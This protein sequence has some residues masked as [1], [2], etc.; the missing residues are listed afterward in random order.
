MIIDTG[1]WI[2]L[3]EAAELLGVSYQTLSAY[4]IRGQVIPKDK[5]L[6]VWSTVV[7]NRQWVLDRKK[8]LQ[9]KKGR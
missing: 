1:E 2:T 8:R 3:G 7:L 4:I 5:Y 6:R 9:K